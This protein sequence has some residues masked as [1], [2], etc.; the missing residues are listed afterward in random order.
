ITTNWKVTTSINLPRTHTYI[1]Y[2]PIIGMDYFQE[3]KIV[4]LY[5]I[6]RFSKNWIRSRCLPCRLA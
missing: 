6:Y 3:W 2:F 4:V 5:D 1:E